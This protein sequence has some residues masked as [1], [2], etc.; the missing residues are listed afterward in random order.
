MIRSF[1]ELC[2]VWD[3][4]FS[5]VGTIEL[6]QTLIE[7]IKQHA[8]VP[9]K[10]TQ[11]EEEQRQQIEQIV[12]QHRR[13]QQQLQQQTQQLLEGSL[14]LLAQPVQRQHS[15]WNDYHLLFVFLFDILR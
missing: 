8:I 11:Q 9:W 7:N 3:A 15:N 6:D 13:R 2:Q 14:Q 12:Q 1:W 10:Q 4:P 5:N